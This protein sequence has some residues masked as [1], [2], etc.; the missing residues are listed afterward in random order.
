MN[1]GLKVLPKSLKCSILSKITERML[2][3]CDRPT[4]VTYCA[5]IILFLH[6]TSGGLSQTAAFPLRRFPVF[7]CFKCYWASFSR[8]KTGF[9]PNI[10]QP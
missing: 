7:H 2:T 8:Y 5:D 9:V 10:M 3:F 4:D 6:A 1:S